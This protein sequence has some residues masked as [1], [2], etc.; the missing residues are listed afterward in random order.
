MACTQY[1]KIF[2]V[3]LLLNANYF[4][5]AIVNATKTRTNCPLTAQMYK[6]K[7]YNQSIWN[8]K[9]RQQKTVNA[10]K[11]FRKWHKNIRVSLQ[12]CIFRVRAQKA[13]CEGHTD[14][15]VYTISCVLLYPYSLFTGFSV[16]ICIFILRGQKGLSWR[17]YGYNN[18]YTA[19]NIYPGIQR[20]F[21]I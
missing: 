17:T 5:H 8:K 21:I 13:Y 9:H 20:Y 1:V 3:Y 16:R 14:K 15:A 11:I 7:M 18:Q 10:W 4:N 12:I 2:H 19:E 6:T